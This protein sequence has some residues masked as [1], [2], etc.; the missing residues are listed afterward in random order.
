MVV[1]SVRGRRRYIALTT[2]K[3]A[4]RDTV[5]GILG[6]LDPEPQMLKVITCGSGRA[7]VRCGPEDCHRVIAALQEAGEEYSSMQ[8]S[9]TLKTLRDR[10]PE[11]RVPQRRKR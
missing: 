5:S 3:S 1:K 11:L 7:V 6:A 8:I 4:N 10:H 9:G 2:P